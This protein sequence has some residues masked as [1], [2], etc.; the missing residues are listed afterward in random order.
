LD[1]IPQL[2]FVVWEKR[3][4][5][6]VD[7]RDPIFFWRFAAQKRRFYAAR[8]ALEKDSMLDSHALATD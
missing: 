6:R 1:A 7:W 4:T 5:S 3:Q 8:L 2:G